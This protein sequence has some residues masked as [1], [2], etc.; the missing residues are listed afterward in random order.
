VRA[1]DRVLMS[2]DY[3]IP[4]F[5]LPKVWVAYWNRLRHPATAPIAGYDLD[6]WWSDRPKP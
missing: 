5:C 1:L 6:S 3:V 4:L 2:G